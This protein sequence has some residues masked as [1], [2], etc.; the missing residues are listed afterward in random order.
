MWFYLIKFA[1]KSM[2]LNNVGQ[3]N[4][5][6]NNEIKQKFKCNLFYIIYNEMTFLNGFFDIKHFIYIFY[7]NTAI[8]IGT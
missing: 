3:K 8:T 5:N 7:F 6:N 1:D 2:F 4:K